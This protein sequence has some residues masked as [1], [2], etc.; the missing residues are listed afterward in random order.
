M[1]FVDEQILVIPTLDSEARANLDAELYK[2]FRDDVTLV[3]IP[4]Q[5]GNDQKGNCGMYT[6]ILATD[7]FLYVPVFGNDPENWK[8]GHSTMMDK[9]VLHML[10][11]NTRKTV[12]PVSI[13]RAICER[14]ISL[15]SLAWTLKGNVADR[16]IEVARNT[17]V[18]LML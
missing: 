14:G 11:V 4:A 7:K 1:S 12:V 15:R 16:L 8:R 5:L 10:E 17:A 13:P 18:R 9:M 6:A 2:K 3:D